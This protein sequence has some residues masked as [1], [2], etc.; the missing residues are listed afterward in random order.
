MS[1]IISPHTGQPFA[2]T[3]FG[4]NPNQRGNDRFV[5]GWQ[6]SPTPID[7]K[8]HSLRRKESGRA[9]DQ[10]RE[11]GPISAAL[12]KQLDHIIGYNLKLSA[13][14]NYQ[15]LGL[16]EIW[17][18][19]FAKY[20][21]PR[22]NEWSSSIDCEC[23]A[24]EQQ[25]VIEMI[26]MGEMQRMIHGEDILVAQWLPDRPFRL[27][28]AVQAISAARLSNPNGQQNS[29]ELTDGV[30]VNGQ[31]ATEGYWF[32][33]SHPDDPHSTA[34]QS[35]DYIEKRTPFGRENVI[36]DF[37]QMEPGQRRGRSMLAPILSRSRMYDEYHGLKLENAAIEAMYMAYIESEFG[38]QQLGQ[39][40]GLGSAN[41]LDSQLQSQLAF[42]QDNEIRLG[43]VKIPHLFPGE[44]LKMLTPNNA[45]PG[46]EAFEKAM[47][48][49]EA[50]SVQMP[51]EMF[52][53]NYSDT[54]YSGARTGL[55]NFYKYVSTRRHFI[56]ARKCRRIYAL[57]L[58][59]EMASGNV[60]MP[61]NAP[62]F[63]IFRSAY[64]Q[65][66]WIGPGK[67]V[68]DPEREAK[69]YAILLGLGLITYEDAYAEL[70]GQDF[71]QA[72]EQIAREKAKMQELGIQ[73]QDIKA[74]SI[75]ASSGDMNAE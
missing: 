67:G 21:E 20:I 38:S 74:L 30:V 59:E 68:V 61:R 17:Q 7:A 28:T 51:Y 5:R 13:R 71:E 44:K 6:P 12:Q 56:G 73:P 75:F 65:S 52:S 15:V 66:R 47:Q 33:N 14:P 24:S 53:G 16:D 57:F 54:N 63:Q 31:G 55:L 35:W 18:K 37:D 49:W 40:L 72:F 69:F 41:T 70:W 39:T 29:A 22:W 27:S 3:E 42:H 1:S 32:Q 10:S 34:M 11:D 36:H 58:E 45:G 8:M 23:D 9:L 26:R 4:A 64:T 43:G 48:R 60:P 46:Y 19:E 2:H 50:T 62:P 25:T